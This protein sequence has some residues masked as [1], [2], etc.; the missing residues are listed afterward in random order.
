MLSLTSFSVFCGCDKNGQAFSSARASCS[1]AELAADWAAS[2]RDLSPL[3][4][5]QYAGFASICFGYSLHALC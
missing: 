1:L 3:P 5:W 4:G 2:C